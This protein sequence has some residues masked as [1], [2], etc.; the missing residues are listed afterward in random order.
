MRTDRKLMRRVGLLLAVGINL[1]TCASAWA[2]PANIPSSKGTPPQFSAKNLTPANGQVTVKIDQAQFN[3]FTAN[4]SN[5][6]P[7]GLRA[8]AKD[9]SA[10]QGT[11][12]PSCAIDTGTLSCT[13]QGLEN[14]TSYTVYLGLPVVGS[15]TPHPV[16]EQGTWPSATPKFAPVPAMTD[17]RATQFGHSVLVS[18]TAP[19]PDP[20]TV[21]VQLGAF[22]QCTEARSSEGSVPSGACLIPIGSKPLRGEPRKITIT[23]WRN[24]ASDSEPTPT[25]KIVTIGPLEPKA[26]SS[27]TWHVNLLLLGALVLAF[28]LGLAASSS[29]SRRR[30]LRLQTQASST[31]VGADPVAPV[32]PTAPSAPRIGQSAQSGQSAV[33][34]CIDSTAP[35]AMATMVSVAAPQGFAVFEDG[36][37]R[38]VETTEGQPALP[39][40]RVTAVEDVVAVDRTSPR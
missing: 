2:D 34:R 11:N 8:W 20:E 22:D 19:K 31:V 9:D 30:A 24:T 10:L 35:S 38:R 27:S 12:D 32:A 26:K 40:Q 3:R 37:A 39:G 28:S 29:V 4:S 1:G 13:I 17:V 36:I 25:V 14:G 15:G 7:K 33:V 16:E 21:T 5:S 23:A 6:K 18:W